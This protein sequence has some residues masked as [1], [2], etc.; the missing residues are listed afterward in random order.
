VAP[1]A[2]HWRS[3]TLQ[4]RKQAQAQAS[5]HAAAAYGTFDFCH[6]AVVPDMHV[7]EVLLAAT[8]V[9]CM[10]LVLSAHCLA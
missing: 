1:Y 4:R 2:W 8:C 5:Q 6:D 10:H 9:F 7:R 3:I